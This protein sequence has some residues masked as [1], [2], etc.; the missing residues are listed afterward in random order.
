MN[1]ELA[2]KVRALLG[3]RKRR[4]RMSAV[5]G[6]YS[7]LVAFAVFATLMMP[8][9][10]MEQDAPLFEADPATAELGTDITVRVTA[11]AQAEGDTVFLISAAAQGGALGEGHVFDSE[12]TTLLTTADGEQLALH[13]VDA[14]KDSAAQVDESSTAVAAALAEIAPP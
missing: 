1:G 10:S 9:I 11:S 13:Q 6:V 7:V 3:D 5:T 8:A 2:A 12:G 14:E 4:H